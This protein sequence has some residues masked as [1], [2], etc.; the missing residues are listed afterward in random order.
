MHKICAPIY[1]LP[2]EVMAH[3]LNG[4]DSSGRPLFDPLWRFAARATCRLW[5]DILAAPEVVEARAI[6]RAWRHGRVDRR[7]RVHC[8]CAPCTHTDGGGLKH[9]IAT[10]RLVTA[11]CAVALGSRRD[12]PDDDDLFDARTWCASSIPDQDA[13]LC[14]AMA[15]TT[16]EAV[17]RVVRDRL[18]PLFACD[19][20]GR[21]LVR[22]IERD[23]NGYYARA[24]QWLQD[25]AACG[26][27]DA[28]AEY[29]DGRVLIMDLLAVAA[30]Q[31]RVT[32]L[33]SLVGLSERVRV[34]AHEAVTAIVYY[35]CSTDRA[36]TIAWVLRNVVGLESA[37]AHNHPFS[38]P[39]APLS[40]EPIDK[41]HTR[42]CSAMWKA[43]ALYDAVD[44]MAMVFD[45]FG[46]HAA[47]HPDICDA[48]R[49]PGTK[50][51][52][53]RAARSGS[54][55]VLDLCRKRGIALHFDVILIE[56]AAYGCG[57]VVRWALAHTPVAEPAVHADTCMRALEQATCG[58]PR[59]S[60]TVDGTDLA[61]DLLC[62]NVSQTWEALPGG[63]ED[64]ARRAIAWWHAADWRRR[65]ACERSCASTMRVALRWRD[66]LVDH[67]GPGDAVGFFGSAIVGTDYKT[68]DTA[69]SLFAGHRAA[70]GVDLWSMVL[71]TLYTSG[72]AMRPYRRHY[73]PNP[74]GSPP[75]RFDRP[76]HSND[77]RPMPADAFFRR[78]DQGEAAEM[79][80]FL[81]SVC[82]HRRQ[83]GS[84]TRAQWR[85]IC[86]IRP[87]TM[88][89][90]PF[91]DM[92]YQ[93]AVA[94]PAWLDARGLLTRPS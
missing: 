74:Y 50:R 30:R 48:D 12:R 83:V 19:A 64:A 44:T 70:D 67:L 88:D 25:T 80:M 46:Q 62:D 56:G 47:V 18:A 15:A 85:S 94:L 45:A 87:V 7:E 16:R 63:A 1:G 51:W 52:Q 6:V 86:T 35:A 43:I 82:A 75:V 49:A 89:R 84:A 39:C 60:D 61:I 21:C 53:K 92:G 20:D 66:L 40:D 17:D 13:A 2:V 72:M 24:R 42:T 36:D 68:L 93:T 11:T 71:D 76:L 5:R 3:V 22:A 31:G 55:R 91:I 90:L 14:V 26:E 54:V 41:H 23:F 37:S 38:L 58:A 8:H 69:V 77:L 33:A 81:A 78:F 28:D 73:K 10:G 57:P 65:S 29:D 27:E 4:L 34:F 59:G 9:L 79:V 32:V